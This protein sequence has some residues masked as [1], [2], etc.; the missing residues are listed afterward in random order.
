MGHLILLYTFENIK[1]ILE[2]YLRCKELQEN[3]QE[4]EAEALVFFRQF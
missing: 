3:G 1:F 2:A 4:A